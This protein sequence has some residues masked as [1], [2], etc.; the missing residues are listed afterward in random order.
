M[1]IW[2][3]QLS[4]RHNRKFRII[5]HA[6]QTFLKFHRGHS[7]VLASKIC[8]TAFSKIKQATW[9][10]PSI[11]P[12]LHCGPI[13]YSVVTVRL[14]VKGELSVGDGESGTLVSR[15]VLLLSTISHSFSHIIIGHVDKQNERWVFLR[16]RIWPSSKVFRGVFWLPTLV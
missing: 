16:V 4:E 1:T 3:L 8:N 12:C 7:Y 6:M 13:S 14:L 9:G 11:P 10:P 2:A 15:H 5:C